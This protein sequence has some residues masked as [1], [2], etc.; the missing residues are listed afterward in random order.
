[1]PVCASAASACTRAC[2]R[3]CGPYARACAC[4]GFVRAGSRARQFAQ[5]EQQPAQPVADAA[6]QLMVLTMRVVKIKFA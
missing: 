4:R 3:A 6:T 2:A 5:N 1:M